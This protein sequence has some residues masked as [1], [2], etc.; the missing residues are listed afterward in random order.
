MPRLARG[1]RMS[2]LPCA[3]SA[4][5]RVRGVGGTMTSV[6]HTGTSRTDRTRS[7]GNVSLGDLAR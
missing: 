4:E 7:V 3:P 6:E 5:V 1:I 2:P